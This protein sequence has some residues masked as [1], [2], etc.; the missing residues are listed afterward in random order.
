[1]K[2]FDSALRP[3]ALLKPYE[4]NA[5]THSAEQIAQIAASISEWGFANPIL[6]DENDWLKALKRGGREPLQPREKTHDD[7]HV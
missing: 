3:P 5:R 4:R 6:I 1:M 7:I 2:Q